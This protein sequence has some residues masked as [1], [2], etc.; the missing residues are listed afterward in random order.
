MDQL[1]S[2]TTKQ[3]PE[4][5]FLTLGRSL[6]Y[7]KRYL[8]PV[9]KENHEERSASVDSKR[10]VT[11]N[12]EA[13]TLTQNFCRTSF[14]FIITRVFKRN[15]QNYLWRMF[16]NFL[17]AP[18]PRSRTGQLRPP[19]YIIPTLRRIVL[20]ALQTYV[21]PKHWR[22]PTSL[23]GEKIHNIVLTAV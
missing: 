8:P 13:V 23:Q 10:P 5:Y 4:K 19:S 1:E 17:S 21:S 18:K 11:V 20:S 2:M 3:N 7:H 14:I 16:G 6:F 12:T 9:T 15:T 22:L